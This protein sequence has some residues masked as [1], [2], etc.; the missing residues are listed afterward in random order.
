MPQHQTL[1]SSVK[2]PVAVYL[3]EFAYLGTTEL[4]DELLIQA[5]SAKQARRFAKE[6]AAHWGIELFAITQATKQ[7]VR[8][9]RLLGRSVLLSAA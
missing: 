3:A 4:A 2:Q 8:L 7:Q 9:Y 5:E 6:Y 1:L